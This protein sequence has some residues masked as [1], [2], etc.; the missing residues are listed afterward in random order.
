MFYSTENLQLCDTY[1][2]QLDV[3][4][5]YLLYICWFHFSWC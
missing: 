1:Q 3:S 5:Y 4:I 2:A